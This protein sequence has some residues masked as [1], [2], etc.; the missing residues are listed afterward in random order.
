MTIKKGLNCVTLAFSFEI[1]M[2][3]FVQQIPKDIL[4]AKRR[5]LRDN[6]LLSIQRLLCTVK[7][8]SINDF[9]TD[10]LGKPFLPNNDF[11]FSISKTKGTLA[12]L[13]SCNSE[14]G[15]D[16][17]DE[18][19]EQF[20]SDLDVYTN[21]EKNCGIIHPEYLPIIFTRKEA[22]LKAAG[23]GFRAEPKNIDVLQQ[24]VT[25]L[26]K[27]FLISSFRIG[28]L[29]IIVSICALL[30]PKNIPPVQVLLFDPK[31][32]QFQALKKLQTQYLHL[33]P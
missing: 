32:S 15:V 10:A 5:I 30:S 2:F 6:M 3:L 8:N 11:K 26:Q 13:S 7:A 16:I 20:F 17:L 25:F 33:E 4:P 19:E 18:G 14:V 21:E 12:I 29:K 24:E 22:L 1:I 31:K 27:R 9:R 23:L 28:E